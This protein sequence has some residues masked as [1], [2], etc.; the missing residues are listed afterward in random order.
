M[1]ARQV[2]RETPGAAVIVDLSRVREITAEGVRG[3]LRCARTLSEAGAPL[4]LTGA[5]E[6]VA[7][8]L[9]TVLVDGTI[10]LYATV[11][12]AVAACG[13]AAAGADTS[14]RDSSARDTSARDTSARDGGRTAVPELI[15]LRRETV[16]LRARLRSHP[17]I[18]QAQG[19]AQP[20]RR[21]DRGP[22]RPGHPGGE[23]AGVA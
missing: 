18:A 23:V 16:D 5:T 3:L 21:G 11:E 9:R 17:L 6:P 1:G 14:A 7:R 4:L 2:G 12:A 19:Q 22:A 10:R 20:D 13:G 8:L 15:R